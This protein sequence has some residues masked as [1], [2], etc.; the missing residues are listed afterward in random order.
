MSL[1]IVTVGCTWD[2]MG[3]QRSRTVVLDSLIQVVRT[4]RNT[5]PIT[6]GCCLGPHGIICE[7]L[8]CTASSSGYVSSTCEARQ[9]SG[10]GRKDCVGAVLVSQPWKTS[11]PQCHLHPAW[12]DST[13]VELPIVQNYSISGTCMTE[14]I[15]PSICN[16]QGQGISITPIW[17]SDG[18]RRIG[19]YE[20]GGSP[21]AGVGICMR[22]AICS[23]HIP[24]WE[25]KT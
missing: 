9:W 19:E 11:K 16:A 6:A 22:P 13:Y 25:I 4:L 23:M 21:E 2:T 24:R 17:F 10:I 5:Y 1:G 8:P 7:S 3:Q 18:S 20:E 14:D 15:P 12:N